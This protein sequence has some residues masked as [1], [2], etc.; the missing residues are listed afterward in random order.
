MAE[1]SNAAVLKTVDCNRSGGSNPSLSADKK[2]PSHMGLFLCISISYI[3][4]KFPKIT[5][6]GPKKG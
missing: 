2:S 1:R 5:K 6:K 4:T 3:F